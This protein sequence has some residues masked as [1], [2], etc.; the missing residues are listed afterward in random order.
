VLLILVTIFYTRK[1]A[2]L[3]T[4]D[5]QNLFALPV[6]KFTASVIDIG[7]K[8][9]TSVADTRGKFPTSGIALIFEKILNDPNIFF[10]GGGLGEDES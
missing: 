7:D 5:L 10:L 3:Q 9:A 2:D 6:G 8:Y 1:F 4:C